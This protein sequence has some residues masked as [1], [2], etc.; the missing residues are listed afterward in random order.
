VPKVINPAGE[1]VNFI[2]ILPQE[3]TMS[4]KSPNKVAL[5]TGATGTFGSELALQC[6]KAGWETILLGKNNRR[7][8]ALYDRL[9]EAG[10]PDPQ[11]MALDM[12]R[13]GPDECQEMIAAIENSTGRLDALIHCAVTFP[14]LRPL[15]QIKPQDW[16]SEV[17]INL[18]VPWLLSVYCLPLLRESLEPSLIFL[19]EDMEK[20]SAAYWGSYGVCKHG[21][22]AMS[23]QFQAELNNTSIQVLSINPGPMQSSLR[24]RVYHSE[25]PQSPDPA[26]ISAKKTLRLL[27]RN[28][29][30][31][32][33]ILNLQDM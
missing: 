12:T 19:T 30:P 13:F 4:I 26:A 32:S 10:G 25:D 7:L 16:L 28:L 31:S 15:D 21:I 29:S 3:M 2:L 27:E 23:L 24:A 9:V 22:Q 11:I 1:A 6:A 5:I 18:N 14:G 17:Q 20:M 8:E 33:S